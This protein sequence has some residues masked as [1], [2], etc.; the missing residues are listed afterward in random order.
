MALF[1]ITQTLHVST[2]SPGM[3]G[4]GYSVMSP[5][6]QGSTGTIHVRLHSVMDAENE[7]EVRDKLVDYKYPAFQTRVEEVRE[8]EA[9]MP[10]REI[11][12]M[13]ENRRVIIEDRG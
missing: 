8:I 3:S 6:A 11:K 9:K 4:D 10:I 13:L 2:V 1:L 12:H 7:E 5:E